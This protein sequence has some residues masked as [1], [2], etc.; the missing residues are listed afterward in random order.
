MRLPRGRRLAFGNSLMF[1][2]SGNY[3]LPLVDLAFRGDPVAVTG[4]LMIILIQNIVA[5]RSASSR[6][7]GEAR[8]RARP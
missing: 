3:G 7:E 5:I 4:Q 6:R 8:G 2:N 1:F